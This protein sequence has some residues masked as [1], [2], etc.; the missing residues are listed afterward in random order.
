MNL[1][2][3]HQPDLF[4]HQVF[5]SYAK[6][7]T[8]HAL[9]FYEDLKAQGVIPWID[10]K[11]LAPGENWDLGIKKAIRQC[12]YILVLLSS[13]SVNKRGYVQKEIR[14]ALDVADTMPDDEIFILPVRLEECTVPDR[15]ARWHWTDAFRNDERN[16]LIQYL[17]RQLGISSFPL[18]KEQE[19]ELRLTLSRDL[20][21]DALLFEKFSQTY[22]VLR[23]KTA[24][25]KLFI[26]NAICLEIRKRSTKFIRLFDETF[27]NCEKRDASFF[28]RF[29]I[30]LKTY[31][32]PQK[33]VDKLEFDSS[34]PNILKL[35]TADGTESAINRDYWT[36]VN[37]KYPNGVLYVL[38]RDRPMVVEEGQE[39]VFVVMPMRYP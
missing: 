4:P 27:P 31:R 21:T 7:D 15:L 38:D 22:R 36:Y 11:Q 5:I 9:E 34:I 23:S 30:T 33:I 26:S 32:E 24:N 17:K 28:R 3:A 29:L 35:R 25:D 2:K 16:K 6:E 10:V 37:L 39:V 12:R 19:R 1:E 18:L 8:K 14:E 20:I 13:R